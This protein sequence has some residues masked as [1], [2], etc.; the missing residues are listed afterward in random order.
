MELMEEG[1]S[2]PPISHPDGERTAKEGM[3]EADCG[4]KDGEVSSVGQIEQ[5]Q[6][7][8]HRQGEVSSVGQIEQEQK[9]DHR[10]LIADAIALAFCAIIIVPIVMNG[11]TVVRRER[12]LTLWQFVREY[13]LLDRHPSSPCT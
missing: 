4:E 7:E 9:E 10:H 8:D 12:R 1:K 5:E 3:T 13:I 2:E 6:K 11:I